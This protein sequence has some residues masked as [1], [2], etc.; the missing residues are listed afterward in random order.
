MTTLVEAIRQG[1]QWGYVNSND[2]TKPTNQPTNGYTLEDV[3]GWFT[4]SHGPHEKKG[5]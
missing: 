1:G 5:K 4:Y 3:P 2:S